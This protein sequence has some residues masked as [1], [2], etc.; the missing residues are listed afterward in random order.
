MRPVEILAA[1]LVAAFVVLLIVS[2]SMGS[3]GAP[4]IDRPCSE[5]E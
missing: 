1:I 5:A 2:G 3:G 4:C